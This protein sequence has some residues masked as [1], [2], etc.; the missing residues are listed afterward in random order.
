MI[1]FSTN[2]QNYV[3]F[4]QFFQPISKRSGTLGYLDQV[5]GLF[6]EEKREK[7]KK[8]KKKEKRKEND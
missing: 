5:E 4:S 7:K 1:S 3:D 8:R 2:H 6:E